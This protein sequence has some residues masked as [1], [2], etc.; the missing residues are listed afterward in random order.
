MREDEIERGEIDRGG[1][2]Q[3]ERGKERERVCLERKE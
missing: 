3:I 2:R 1:N